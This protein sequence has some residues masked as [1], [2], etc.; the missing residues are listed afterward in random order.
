M[1]NILLVA[2]YYGI[3]ILKSLFLFSH[4]VFADFRGR[5]CPRSPMAGYGRR[6]HNDAEEYETHQT[7]HDHFSMC[8]SKNLSKYYKIGT[9]AMEN[10]R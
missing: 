5:Q 10:V 9:E 1:D 4:T 3:W 6:Q 2:D 8:C 7:E